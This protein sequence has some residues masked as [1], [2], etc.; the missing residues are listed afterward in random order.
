[1]LKLFVVYLESQIHDGI[2]KLSDNI[3]NY[4]LTK[5]HLLNFENSQFQNRFSFFRD[6]LYFAI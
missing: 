6:I 3:F 5:I 1:M 2:T 4:R